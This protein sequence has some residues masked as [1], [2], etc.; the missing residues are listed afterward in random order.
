MDIVVRCDEWSRVD[1]A[2][3]DYS[4]LVAYESARSELLDIAR[5]QVSIVFDSAHHRL[6]G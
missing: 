2:N 1:R 3:G 5:V 4:G 6:S